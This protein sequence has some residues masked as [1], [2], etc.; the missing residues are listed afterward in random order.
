MTARCWRKAPNQFLEAQLEG[1]RTR[2]I[3]QKQQLNAA[4]HAGSPQAE[5]MA[6][7][8]EVL[9]A[10]F[11]DLLTKLEDSQL[12]S[13]LEHR[14]IGEQFKLLDPARV[15]EGPFS[16]DRRIYAGVGAVAGLAAGLRLSFRY[17]LD[18]LE[19]EDAT[20]GCSR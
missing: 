18:S 2:L 13:N 19:R 17:P 11:R 16:P 12:A 4:R 20:T 6:I 1:L 3:R 14:Q 15:A 10:T 8:S 9:E 7:E 5:T